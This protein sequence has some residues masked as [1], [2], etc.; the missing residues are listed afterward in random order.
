MVL[1]VPFSCMLQKRLGRKPFG[2]VS[3]APTPGEEPTLT[4]LLWALSGLLVAM[5]LG[6]FE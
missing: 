3:E 2:S 6:V 1:L 5:S 4:E